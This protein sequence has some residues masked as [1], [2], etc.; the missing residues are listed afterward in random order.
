MPSCRLCGSTTGFVKSHIIP[1]AF[2][3]E[4]RD[5][6]EAPILVSGSPGYFPKRSPIGIYDAEILCSGCESEFAQLDSYGIE[7]LLSCFGSFFQPMVLSGVAEGFES[8]TVDKLKL[9]DFL[10]SVLWRASVSTQAFYRKVDLGPYE[11]LAIDVLVA[12]SHA[13]GVFDAVLARWEDNDDDKLPTSAILDPRP[14]RWDGIHSYRMYLGKIVAFVRVDKRPFAKPFSELSLRSEGPCRII[15][16][17]LATSKDLDAICKT[18]LTS[19]Q[20][21]KKFASKRGRSES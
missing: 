1:E 4:I 13:P 2:F 12:G 17:R 9:L 14:E 19:E 8:A 3:R 20:N 15:G 21:K 5:G 16:R 7:V 11:Q 18:V 6:K 10:V